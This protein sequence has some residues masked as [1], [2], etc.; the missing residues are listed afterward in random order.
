MQFKTPEILYFLFLLIIPILIHLFQLQKFQKVAFT[1][2]KILQ[3]IEQETRKSSKLKKILILLSRLLLFAS[4]IIAFAQPFIS[5]KQ[6]DLIKETFIYLDNSWSMQAKG[7]NGELLQKAKNDLIEN[8]RDNTGKIT[9]ITNDQII[10]NVEFENFKNEIIKIDY[11]PIKKDLNNVL[12]QI[13]NLQ[14][15]KVKSWNNVL[16]ISDFQRANKINKD[17]FLDSL[18]T[19]SFIQTTPNKAENISIDSIWASEKNKDNIKIKARI[20]SYNLSIKN[21]SISLFITDKLFGKTTIN[22]EK[23]KLETIEFSIPFEQNT[24]GYISLNDQKLPF[25]NTMYFSFP[26]KE[27]INV[28][29]IGEEAHFLSKIYTEEDF[30]FV[31]SSLKSL[32]Y[33]LIA[34]QQVIVLNDIKY[35]PNT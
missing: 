26:N 33:T 10:K 27:K 35:L 13:Q 11:Y 23:N 19:Y 30:N 1:N 2:V 8:L 3:R 29:A 9:L 24:H 4:L 25:D 32:D 15:K 20:K 22:L 28:L 18:S 5:Q 17:V 14:N 16:L 31:S 34:K 6:K 12:L 7:E 21:L